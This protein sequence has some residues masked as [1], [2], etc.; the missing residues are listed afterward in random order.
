MTN[1]FRV[2]IT[3]K[4][5]DC[6]LQVAAFA[7]KNRHLCI[8]DGPV[9][10][11]INIIMPKP[12]RTNICAL[13]RKIEENLRGCLYLRESQIKRFTVEYS[14]ESESGVMIN[15]DAFE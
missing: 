15:V 6:L 8:A 1:D 3:G 12:G 4:P 2:T 10:V 11:W 9:S 13:G 5:Q 7:M 14:Y